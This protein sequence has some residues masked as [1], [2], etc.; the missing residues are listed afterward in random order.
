MKEI[1]FIR[2][3]LPLQIRSNRWQC[4]R[5]LSTVAHNRLRTRL[6][7]IASRLAVWQALPPSRH[8][9]VLLVS[10]MPPLR[11]N[12]ASALLSIHVRSDVYG[13]QPL[14]QS[15]PNP[16]RQLAPAHQTW[17]SRAPIRPCVVRRS[18]NRPWCIPR[19]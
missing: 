19:L 2:G 18:S 1:G 16:V 15:A 3:A 10:R 12:C 9:C 5:R 8:L 4:R 11:R 13:I 17:R 6:R 7:T 14:R